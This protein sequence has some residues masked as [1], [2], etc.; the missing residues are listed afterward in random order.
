MCRCDR[1]TERMKKILFGIFA[2]PDDEAF[3]PAG[4]L[5]MEAA[6]GVEVQMVTLTLG[7]AGVNPDNVPNLMDVRE[8]EWRESG[9]LI[10]ARKLHYLGYKDGQLTN[11]SMVEIGRQLVDLITNEIRSAVDETE[12]ELM[13]IDLNGV[14][15][16][17]DHI[18]AARATCWA[19]YTLRKK[20]SRFKK[21]R[22]VCLPY[23]HAPEPN[24]DWIYMEPGRKENE[25]DE[26]ID[27]RAYREQIIAIMRAHHSQR[28]DCDQHLRNF[29]DS[30]GL[31]YFR[32]IT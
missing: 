3:G 14:T 4:T 31:N 21:V 2:H 8:K 32:V 29:G 28:A 19:Y 25:I 11:D 27:A 9:R 7:E 15:G 12:I 5:L 26:V 30:I 23:Q 16:H 13:T 1:Y 20:D 24:V 17:I 6:D 22:L 18:V 10:G